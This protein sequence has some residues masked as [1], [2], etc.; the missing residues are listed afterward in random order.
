VIDDT[1]A[2]RFFEGENPIGRKVRMPWGVFEVVG[3]AASVKNS[4]L[5][6]EAAPEI[7]FP[8][9]SNILQFTM[10]IRTERPSREISKLVAGIVYG[11][12]SDQ[13]IYNI[14]PEE[15]FVE[16]SLKT[17]RF[18]VWLAGA[19]AA[20]GTGLASLG[21]FNL[22]SYTVQIRRREIGIRMAVG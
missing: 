12:D 17:R 11:I 5:D 2:R 19:F 21:V 16:K 20:I 22:L 10:V 1:L 4:A 8:A 14:F 15:E 7:Y 18:V 3:V 9:A 13:P 6:L